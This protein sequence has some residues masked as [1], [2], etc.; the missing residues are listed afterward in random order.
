PER[1][2]IFLGDIIDRGPR[3]RESLHIVHDMVQAGLA[4]RIMG[5]HEFNALGWVTPALPESGHR[6]VREHTP[7]HAKLIGETLAQFEQHPDEWKAFVEW[8]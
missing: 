3:I 1:I 2:A 8:F 6:F 5:N 4:Y 7:R